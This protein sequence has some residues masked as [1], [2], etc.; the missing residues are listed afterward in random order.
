MHV[1]VH[2]ATQPFSQQQETGDLYAAAGR[3]GTGAADHQTKQNGLGKSRPA[4]KI[5]NG[6]SGGGNDGGDRKRRL[7]HHRPQSGIQVAD[8]PG[9]AQNG[10]HDNHQI[11]AQFFIKKRAFKT[12]QQQHIENR[13]I[14]SEQQHERRGHRLGKGGIAGHGIIQ[15]PEAAGSGRAESD[16]YRV[17]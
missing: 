4:V 1:D 15:N 10:Q 5:R 2:I 12:L 7:V 13:E 17:E 6:E 14:D 3:P 11:D 9:D 8:I 16:A